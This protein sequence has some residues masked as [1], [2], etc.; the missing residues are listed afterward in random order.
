MFN[1]KLNK[2]SLMVRRMKI[3]PLSLKLINKKQR[4]KNELL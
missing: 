3:R 1:L 4:K 2:P